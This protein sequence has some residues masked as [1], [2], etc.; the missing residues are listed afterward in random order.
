LII[1]S[2][3]EAHKNRTLVFDVVA[4]DVDFL[5]PIFACIEVDYEPFDDYQEGKDIRNGDIPKVLT[6]Y[7]HDLGVNHVTRKSSETV[8]ATA[9]KLIPVPGS[10]NGGPGGVFICSEDTL[11]YTRLYKSE[12][13]KKEDQVGPLTV[14]LPKREGA[15]QPVLIVS[16]TM[17][18]QKS[19]EYFFLVQSELGDVFKLTWQIN[20][21]KQMSS[22][23]L[24]YFDTLP[25]ASAL[26]LFKFGFLFIGSEFGNNYLLQFK[27]IGKLRESPMST[28]LL[29]S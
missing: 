13:E 8:P 12:R 7:E 24:Q 16:Y 6:Y 23:S 11:T 17:L 15:D 21:S 26:S 27:N 29:D 5:N 22:L 2:P 3:L 18:K 10:L 1:S 20:D 25:V 4:L 28:N 14:H 19:G 9:N